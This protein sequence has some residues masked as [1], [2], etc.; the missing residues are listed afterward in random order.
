MTQQDIDDVKKIIFD[1]VISPEGRYAA[2]VRRIS[3]T[4]G[5]DDYISVL[6]SFT[7][8]PRFGSVL[9]EWMTTTENMMVWRKAFT[10]A[11]V[12]P[13]C[14]EVLETI[15]DASMNSHFKT[16]LRLANP[17]ITECQMTSLSN[18]YMSKL[19]QP[20]MAKKYSMHKHLVVSP[21]F[22]EFAT[23]EV[24]DSLA[25]DAVEA[26]CGALSILNKTFFDEVSSGKLKIS[27]EMVA[28]LASN[29][30]VMRFLQMYFSFDPVDYKYSKAPSR[31]QIQMILNNLGWP[32]SSPC[33]VKTLGLVAFADEATRFLR[34]KGYKGA[35]SASGRDHEPFDTILESLNSEGFVIRAH[36]DLTPRKKEMDEKYSSYSVNFH[37]SGS[38]YYASISGSLK[39]IPVKRIIGEGLGSD[40]K[41]AL[42]AAVDMA[43]NN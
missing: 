2:F 1:G 15:G 31:N 30:P 37:Q 26:F 33:F 17:D 38:R 12:D 41:E 43:L 24:E 5:F 28:E 11:S 35:T 42:V 40:R 13:S 10:H 7:D 9:R 21:T 27:A 22:R 29:H 20:R 34:S 19:F 8:T 32:R 14:N 3:E 36:E 23:S 18:H 39:T 6:L 25:E 16:Y 4:S